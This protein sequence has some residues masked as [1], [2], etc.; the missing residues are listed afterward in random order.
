MGAVA[1]AGIEHLQPGDIAHQA[2][3]FW[4]LVQRV[5][6]VVLGV[7]AVDP[8]E[9][10]VIVLLVHTGDITP[11]SAFAPCLAARWWRGSCRARRWRR[12]RR[13]PRATAARRYRALDWLG[14][15]Y[16]RGRRARTSTS[17]PRRSR[18]ARRQ[19]G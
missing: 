12:S 9:A 17:P 19:Q 1:A 18:S 8:R 7:L 16:R 3:R 14:A 2:Q 4:P 10:V 5:E 15:P 11:A 6:R 13:R